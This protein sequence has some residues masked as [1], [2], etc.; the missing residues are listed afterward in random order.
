MI[1]LL[2]FIFFQRELYSIISI[3][4]SSLIVNELLMVLLTV[5][6]PQTYMMLSLLVS[7]CFYC[8]SFF[9][10]KDE[11]VF[12]FP[13]FEFLW[14]I[15]LINSISIS[16]SVVQKIWTRIIRPSSAYKLAEDNMN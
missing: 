6:R 1:M 7:L 13:I 9:F 5:H 14:K 11:L 16:F 10:L 15:C 3:T 12:P 2:S 8:A 4:F